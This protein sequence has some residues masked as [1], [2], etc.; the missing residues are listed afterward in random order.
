MRSRSF[1]SR[2][3]SSVEAKEYAYRRNKKSKKETLEI[4]WRRMLNPN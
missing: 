1:T 3:S 2:F 4:R